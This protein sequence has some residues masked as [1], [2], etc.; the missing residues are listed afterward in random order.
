[1]QKNIQGFKY[2]FSLISLF[3]ILIPEIDFAESFSIKLKNSL[4]FARPNE[5]V[6]INAESLIEKKPNFNFDSFTVYEDKKEIFFEKVLNKNTDKQE[7]LLL[8]SFEPGETKEIIFTDSVKNKKIKKLTQAYLGQKTGYEEKEGFFTG[9]YFQ[10]VNQTKVPSGHFAHDALYQFEGPGWESEKVGY[11]LYLDERNRTDIFGKKISGL[12]L[13]I[14]GKNDLVSDGNESYQKMLD[15]GRDIFKVG[16]SLGIGSIATFYNN[17]VVTV[18]EIDSTLCMIF[19]GNLVSEVETTHYGWNLDNKYDITTSYSIYAESRIT[20]INVLIDKNIENLCTGL[21][22]HEN[23]D[24][25]TSDGENWN[26]IA[27]WGKQTVENDNL[28]IVVFYDK[29]NL[30][31]ISEDELSYFVILKPVN[32]KLTYNFSSVWEQEPNGIKS[33]DEFIN[34]LN[35]ELNKLDNPIKVNFMNS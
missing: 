20:Y 14:T 16:N 12:F 25:I 18:S 17:K 6:K 15:W 11:R 22:K 26:Y 2:L 8:I 3:V 28:G 24:Y 21:P 35:D 10:S 5:I 9:G 31:K 27:L 4:N 29:S 19:D 13:D 23:T 33:K 32:N 1:M 7:I 30:V 34:Y